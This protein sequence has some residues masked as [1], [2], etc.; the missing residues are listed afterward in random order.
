MSALPETASTALLLT[1]TVMF[2]SGAKPAPLGVKVNVVPLA[3]QLKIPVVAGAVEK[4]AC[5]LFVF[6][7]LL[8]CSTTGEKMEMFVAACAGKFV[9]TT[10]SSGSTC[11]CARK[12]FAVRL[13][14][15]IAGVCEPDCTAMV[16]LGFSKFTS[17]VPAAYV[18]ERAGSVWLVAAVLK[19]KVRLKESSANHGIRRI[20]IG[21]ESPQS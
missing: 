5:T 11:A 8:N 17:T 10:G 2:V 15:V 18:N 7:G 21:K 12:I 6:I 14:T 4:A 13:G 16:S 9:M 20:R 1:V 19:L 3:D